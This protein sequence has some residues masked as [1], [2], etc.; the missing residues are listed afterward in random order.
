MTPRATLAYRFAIANTVGAAFLSWAFIAGYAQQVL[1]GDISH[2]SYVIAALFAVGL[3]SSALWVGRVYYNDEPAEYFK[4]HT[5]HVSDIA[6]WLVTLGLI[7]NVIGF[8]IA[9]RGVDVGALGGAD[10]AQKV[11][12]QLLAGMGVAF[13]STLTGAVFGL[14]TSINRRLIETALNRMEVE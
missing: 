4:A 9:L 5:A 14:W 6:E 2:I 7:G 1:A 12:V 8:V 3:A 13:Y 10:G 11:A